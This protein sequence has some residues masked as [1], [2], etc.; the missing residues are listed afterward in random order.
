[1]RVF[2]KIKK[3]KAAS[4]FFG[5]LLMLVLSYFGPYKF[6]LFY[7]KH[8][9]QFHHLMHPNKIID[10]SAPHFDPAKFHFED[11]AITYDHKTDYYGELEDAVMDICKAGT[12]IE[13][14]DKAFEKSGGAIKKKPQN[15]ELS[16]YHSYNYR[17]WYIE[18]L[19]LTT[20]T[21]AS[22]GIGSTIV[23]GVELNP[24]GTVKGCGFNKK[25]KIQ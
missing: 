13:T 8:A 19:Y 24:D 7:T 1:M 15:K 12:S 21:E 6:G 22:V 18:A 16:T 3:H 10:P 17:P 2:D 25:V 9:Y 14:L 5:V 20:E 11:Y 4:I 23:I